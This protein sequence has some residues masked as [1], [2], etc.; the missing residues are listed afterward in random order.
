ADEDVLVLQEDDER[1]ELSVELTKSERYIIF[2]S[3]SQV[4]GESR[5]MPSDEPESSP[6]LI[7][8][9]RRGIAYEVDHQEDHFLILTNDGARSF[10]L[11]AAPVERS[12]REACK[13]VVHAR[14]GVRLND[15]DVH[16]GHVVLGQ[17]SDGL[18]R[19][20]VLNI[21]TGELYV[22]DQ[23]DRAYTAFAGSNPVYDSSVMR[24]FYTSLNA[25]WST[26]DFD[27]SSRVRTI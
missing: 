14:D 22:V 10:R 24:F 2:S 25:P 17:R 27:M 1:F 16:I 23:P 19:L 13:D 6:V 12:G 3:S 7:E 21:K 8:A 20:E 18:Q 9:L 5:F 11:M 15:M 26:V 4:T